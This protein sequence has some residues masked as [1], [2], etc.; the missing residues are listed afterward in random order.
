MFPGGVQRCAGGRA[1]AARAALAAGPHLLHRPTKT[2][3]FASE[4]AH[5]TPSYKD[6]I[7]LLPFP[8]KLNHPTK[9]TFILLYIC[10]GSTVIQRRHL[11]AY[12]S[13]PDPQS[14]LLGLHIIFQ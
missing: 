11:S 3:F 5:A 7:H 2:T 8:L 12:F 1:G 14:Y 9:T 4:G 10:T 13:E 6:D